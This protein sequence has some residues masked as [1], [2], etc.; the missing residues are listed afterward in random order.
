MVSVTAGRGGNGV[1]SFRREKFIPH[2]GPDGGDGG[3]GGHVIL[4]ADRD[5]DSLLSLYYA[6]HQRAKDGRPG[7]GARMTGHDGADVV[8]P[9]PC[10]TSVYNRDSG[11]FIGDLVDD[12]TELVIAR[13]GKGGRG[14]WHWR[15]PS[16]QVPMEHSD[17]T[18]GEEL[19]VRL[20]L[21]LVADVGLVGYPNA[22][23]SSLISKISK[24][25]P[26]VAAYPFTTINPIMGT[27]FYDDYSSLRVVDIPGL[28]EGA[29]TGAGLGHAFLRHAER[30]K[31]IV[32]VIDMAGVDGRKPY[33]D[34]RVL[35]REL[36]HCNPELLKRPLLVVANKMDLPEAAAHL[37][38]FKR[39][40]RTKPLEISAQDGVGLKAVTQ[41]MKKLCKP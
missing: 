28:I 31:V 1:C 22:G 40:T 29:H 9:V 15:S 19:Y 12:G 30:T 14:N 36:K 37:K 24:A 5:V 23:K 21:K 6:P 17:G 38:E 4:K 20:E 7:G 16:H 35:R 26:K 27:V 34:Y 25:H 33:E 41:A 3:R 11:A 8:L 2:G 39:K 13:G 32:L 18:E 10:G